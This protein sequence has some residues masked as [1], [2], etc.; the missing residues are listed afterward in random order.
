M[1]ASILAGICAAILL[2]ALQASAGLD[3]KSSGGTADHNMSD[4]IAC[5]QETGEALGQCSYRIDRNDKGKTTVTVVFANG[6]KRR[7]F[8][9]NGAFVKASTTMSGTG[10]DTDW[11]LKDGTHKIRVDDQRY[12]VPET[13]T[14]GN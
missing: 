7:L 8:F 2:G 12:E 10:S 11:S 5:A 6:F 1:K 3:A 13:L 14:A 9:R 4:S